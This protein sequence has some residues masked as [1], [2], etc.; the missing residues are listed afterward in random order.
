MKNCLL[1]LCL[2]FLSYAALSQTSENRIVVQNH[3][4]QV[5]FIVDGEDAARYIP[6]KNFKGLG[7]VLSRYP[8]SEA[9]FRKAKNQYNFSQIFGFIG[10]FMIGY[11]IGTSLAGGEFNVPMAATGAGMIAIA[12]PAA[13]SA[14]QN[15]MRAIDVYNSGGVAPTTQ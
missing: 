7:P 9:L 15:L 5:V 4:K 3:L 11:P 12:F 13:K 6:G 1:I 10:G 14:N 8:E 2:F